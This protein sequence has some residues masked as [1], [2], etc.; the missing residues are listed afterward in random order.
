MAQKSPSS[1]FS[2]WAEI[3][4]VLAIRN[5]IAVGC[6][7]VLFFLAR[8][9]MP[10]SMVPRLEQS[11]READRLYYDT[12]D[13][14]GFGLHGL[15]TTDTHLAVNLVMLQDEAAKLQIESLRAR[16]SLAWWWR[17][18]CAVFNGHSFALWRC[19]WRIRALRNNIHLRKQKKL[20]QLNTEL[21]VGKS[22]VLQLSMR[23]RN[24]PG[25]KN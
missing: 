14:H 5:I 2:F 13:I 16:T 3:A 4:P 8:C 24:F 23:R 15:S 17:E 20:F 9:A 18:L 21:A 7:V 12:F 1:V 25:S 19:T 6:G 22:A 10:T 11:L